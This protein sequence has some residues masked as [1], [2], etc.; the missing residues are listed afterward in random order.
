M[1]SNGENNKHTIKP[2]KAQILADFFWLVFP[3]LLGY[4]DEVMTFNSGAEFEKYRNDLIK[5]LNAEEDLEKTR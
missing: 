5:R 4:G 1:I 2:E 3:P